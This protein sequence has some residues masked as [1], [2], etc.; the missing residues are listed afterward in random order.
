MGD[1]LTT[2]IA[3]FL[4]GVLI[5]IVPLMTIS[6]QRDHAAQLKVETLTT[7]FVDKVRTTGKLTQNALE[8]YKEQ[9]MATGD[10]YEVEIR[11]DILDEN[12]GVK[13][14]Q[15][16]T[17]K[18]GENVYYTLYTSQIEGRLQASSGKTITFKEGDIVSVSVKN[19]NTTIAQQLRN[20]FY[21]LTG[22]DP[23]IVAQDAGMV[24]VN[25]TK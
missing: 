1:S 8:S 23:T 16:A 14:S 4:A 7:Q 19:T 11:V 25:G 22:A 2:I 20:F 9:I 15:A 12:P 24:A 6:S 13:T 10:V 17:T 18:I 21:R 3:I 5:F